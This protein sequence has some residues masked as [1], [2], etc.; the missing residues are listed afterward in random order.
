MP[1]ERAKPPSFKFIPRIACDRIA[2]ALIDY[3]HHFGAR[4]AKSARNLPIE[5]ICSTHLGL[6]VGFTAPRELARWLRDVLAARRA[7]PQGFEDRPCPRC[8]IE[9][10]ESAAPS[11]RAAGPFACVEHG[12]GS[13]RD[14]EDLLDARAIPGT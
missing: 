6:V 13:G 10:R 4:V 12:G 1:R 2:A 14:F 7:D 3:V 8:D 5:R 9:R 11:A